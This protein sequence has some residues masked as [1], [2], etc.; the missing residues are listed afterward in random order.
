M[1]LFFYNGSVVDGFNANR[2][3]MIGVSIKG[4]E[5]D[6][7]TNS[8]KYFKEWIDHTHPQYDKLKAIA[9]TLV[10][11]QVIELDYS[12]RGRTAILSNIIPGEL[13]VDFDSI[14]DERRKT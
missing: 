3:R 1:K 10:P 6:P 4:I 11:G 8:V 12:V 14:L 7:E 13:A 9:L 2:E 5:K